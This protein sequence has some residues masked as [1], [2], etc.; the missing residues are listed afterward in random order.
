MKNQAHARAVDT[1]TS[2]HP[3]PP[4]STA[5]NEHPPPHANHH[6]LLPPA[7]HK[8]LLLDGDK[9]LATIASNILRA[10]ANRKS[11]SLL[12]TSANQGEGKSLIAAHIAC[13]LA[14]VG[15]LRTLLIDGNP[16]HPSL[17]DMFRVDASPGMADFLFEDRTLGEVLHASDM[18]H[19]FLM[20]L[21]TSEESFLSLFNPLRIRRMLKFLQK[22]FQAVVFD[23]P[24][25][26]GPA[27]PELI[28]S[29]FSEVL[30]VVDSGHTRWEVVE[31]AVEQLAEGGAGP[32]GVILNR[33][34]HY[35][36]R[37]IYDKMT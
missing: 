12:V 34:K 32:T 30:L 29:C 15:G 16:D 11:R 13:A 8:F 5:G 20:T 4:F 19:L 23:G 35:I 26:F 28:A 17:H 9:D 14:Q 3:S 1:R 22:P 10:E 18:K 6:P 24:S 25:I 27:D 37:K 2:A 7:T 33:R 21:G 36:P 31:T